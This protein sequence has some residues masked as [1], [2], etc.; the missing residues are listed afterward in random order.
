M[1]NLWPGPV[2][3]REKTVQ[4]GMTDF[5]TGQMMEL[6][7]ED[8]LHS[9][10]RPRVTIVILDK[11]TVLGNLVEKQRILDESIVKIGN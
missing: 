5:V 3:Q 10:N 2:T 4:M 6:Q 1:L 8:R 7:E 9:T 11:D